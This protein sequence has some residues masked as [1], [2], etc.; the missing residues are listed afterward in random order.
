MRLDCGASS[1]VAMKRASVEPTD[2]ETVSLTHLHG[3]HFGGLPFLILDVACPLDGWDRHSDIAFA[4]GPGC[5]HPAGPEPRVTKATLV[6]EHC[7]PDL[8]EAFIAP[9]PAGPLRP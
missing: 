5:D 6:S 7:D 2:V 1:L 9:S 3:D 4:C 8:R